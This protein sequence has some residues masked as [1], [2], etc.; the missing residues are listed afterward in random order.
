MVNRKGGRVPAVTWKTNSTIGVDSQDEMIDEKSVRIST[1]AWKKEK[2]DFAV[3]NTANGFPW[4]W[5]IFPCCCSLRLVTLRFRSL[6]GDVREFGVTEG[7]KL[8][9]S[10]S[11]DGVESWFAR[12]LRRLRVKTVSTTSFSFQQ[13]F[14]HSFSFFYYFST[15]S[16]VFSKSFHPRHAFFLKIKVAEKT[17]PSNF[18]FSSNP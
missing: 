7:K 5:T 11:Q 17:S 8:D 9:A 10:A 3:T 13:N 4:K 1:L 12:N 16:R 2:F 15:L 18:Y 6:L 14:L